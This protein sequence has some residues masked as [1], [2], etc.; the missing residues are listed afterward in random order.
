MPVQATNRLL[1]AL[2]PESRERLMNSSSAVTLPLKTALYD[3]DDTP[4]H[5]YFMTSGMASIVTSMEDGGTAEV[6]VIGLE[7]VVGA[8]H[9]LGPSKNS[10]NCMVQL[11]GT[12]LKIPLR[13]L[14]HAF[15]SSEDIRDRI[16]EFVQSQSLTVSQIAGCNRLHEA[17]E[18]LARWLL[19][20]RDR[21]QSDEM[22][23]TQEF[24]AMMVGARR[25]TVTLIA[26]ALQ[27]ADLIEY[28]RGRV[29]ILD[30]ERLETAA[31]DCYRISR[32]LFTNLYAYPA[33]TF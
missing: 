12:A 3:I 2:S 6:G 30:R 33:Q 27:R 23:F 22:Y 8:Y 21:T 18:R 25:T 26:G 1:S 24:L 17:E 5:A 7:G 9:I 14:R 15:R 20:A 16:L 29:T 10:T 31:C 28:S 32:D 4:T 13:E 11:A 19:M